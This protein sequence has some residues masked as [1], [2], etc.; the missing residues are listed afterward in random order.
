MHWLD[1][2]TYGKGEVK[3]ES[4]CLQEVCVTFMNYRI[5]FQQ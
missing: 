2:H 3:D 5:S 1:M 4:F